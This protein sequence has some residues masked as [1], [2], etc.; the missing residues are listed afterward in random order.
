MDKVTGKRMSP[1]T[2]TQIYWGAIPF[3]IIQIAMVGLLIAFPQMSLVYKSGQP[4]I[5]INKVKV[6]IPQDEPAEKP[7]DIMKQLGAPPAPGKG[8]EP[9]KSKEDDEA[10]DLMKQLGGGRPKK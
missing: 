9:K 7:D 8:E 4:E 2:T 1:V 6:E 10:D 5:D 3:V